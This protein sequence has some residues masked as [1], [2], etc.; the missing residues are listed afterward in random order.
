[1]VEII[2]PGEAII[3][4]VAANPFARLAELPFDEPSA[5]HATTPLEWDADGRQRLEIG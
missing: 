1:M 4:S 3:P 2:G 5:M